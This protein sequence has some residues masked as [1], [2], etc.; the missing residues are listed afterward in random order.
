MDNNSEGV[1][2]TVGFIGL[3]IMGLPMARRLLGAG[4]PLIIWN[5]TAAHCAPLVDQ[6]ASHASSTDDLFE[7]CDVVL[8]MLVNE[9]A[10]DAVL[11]RDTP[12]FA[13]RVRGRTVVTLG[14]TSAAYSAGLEADIRRCGG[15]Y[16]EAPVSG[17]RVPAET[18]AL[19]GMVAG[20]AQAV[21]SVMPVLAPLCQ[22]LV[23]CGAVPAA[24]RTKLA[25]NHFLIVMVTALAEAVSAAEA[26]NVDLDLM[27]QV[28]NAGP[29]ASPVLRSKLDKLLRRDL[30][31]EAAISNVATIAALARDQSRE[32]QA[33]APLIE[34][35]ATLLEAACSR[36]LGDLDM[37]AVF[38]PVA[39]IAEAHLQ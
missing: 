32:A 24:L 26:C 10:V 31:A 17:S 22:R 18:G 13:T 7:R 3:G 34:A 1:R 20:D 30:V 8:L 23:Q 21:A 25:V 4:M 27:Q 6:G 36:G 12:A 35:A 9:A 15:R 11:G 37:A 5:R 39:R 19:V 2:S 28:L 29:I 38:Q 16:V 14:T 33:A